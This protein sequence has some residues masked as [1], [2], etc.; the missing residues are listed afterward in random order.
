MSGNSYE[1]KVYTIDFSVFLDPVEKNVKFFVDL[2]NQNGIIIANTTAPSSY[3]RRVLAEIG[4]D[5]DRPLYII[6]DL[7]DEGEG[8]HKI[9][10][11]IKDV[12]WV[13]LGHFDSKESSVKFLRDNHP[14]IPCSTIESMVRN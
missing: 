5:S 3:I 13:H 11:H 9:I 7:I 12:G 10:S 2:A 1:S 4:V 14:D 6:D 8:T